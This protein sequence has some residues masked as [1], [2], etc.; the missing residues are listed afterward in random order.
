VNKVNSTLKI[1]TIMK[2]SSRELE[3]AL[4]GLTQ[5][6]LTDEK[7]ISTDR[8]E[9]KELESK[10]ASPLK[11]AVIRSPSI[12]LNKVASNEAKS[13]GEKSR[14]QSGRLRIKRNSSERRVFVA[15]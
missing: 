10:V 8:N 6:N 2:Q 5:L 7:I 13:E 15:K 3:H 12:S 4:L 1:E 11:P 9:H 14:V